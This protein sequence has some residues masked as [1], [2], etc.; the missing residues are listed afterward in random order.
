M[1]EVVK[2]VDD[3]PPY[4]REENIKKVLIFKGDLGGSK[5]LKHALTNV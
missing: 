3:P 4:E 1:A 2:I 5:L